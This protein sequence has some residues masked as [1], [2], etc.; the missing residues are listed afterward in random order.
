MRRFALS[1]RFDRILLPHSGLYCL[2]SEADCV[3]CLACIAAHLETGGLLI[4]DAYAAD[5]FHQFAEATT[6]LKSSADGHWKDEEFEPLVSVAQHGRV[7]DVSEATRW[8]PGDQRL[9]VVYRHRPRDGGSPVDGHIP[10]RYLLA[11]QLPGLL[12]RAGLRLLSLHGDFHGGSFG[13]ESDQLV[14]VAR[15]A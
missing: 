2:L 8:T 12:E 15:R 5:S 7:Y 1:R 4:L 9:D 10:Q 6:S 14:A 11:C 13:E 3:R